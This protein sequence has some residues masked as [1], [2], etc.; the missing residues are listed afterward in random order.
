MPVTVVN[1]GKVYN[2]AAKF[3]RAM[4][5]LY[6]RPEPTLEEIKRELALEDEL[7]RG[8]RS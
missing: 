4:P 6:R 5:W 7:R 3:N 8:R 1:D 2:D